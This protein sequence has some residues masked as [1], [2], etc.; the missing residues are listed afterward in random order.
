MKDHAHRSRTIPP[1]SRKFNAVRLVGVFNIGLDQLDLRPDRN[2]VED[3]FNMLVVEADATVRG[4]A[5]D[6]P[7]IVGAVDA[8]ILPGQI[9]GTRSKRVAGVAARHKCWP[10]GIA[11]PH[12]WRRCPAWVDALFDD[13]GI[14]PASQILG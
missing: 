14:A 12:R 10:L 1:G 5:P 8:V 11:L 13:F 2:S 6:F 7:R 9:E 3:F 4:S